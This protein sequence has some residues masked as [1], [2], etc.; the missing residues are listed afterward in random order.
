MANMNEALQFFGMTIQ[1]KR[2]QKGWTQSDLA[3][4][5]KVDEDTIAAIE[6]GE[7]DP[8]IIMIVQ[9]SK[10]LGLE[11]FADIFAEFNKEVY[12]YLDI[13]EEMDAGDKK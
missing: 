1:K 4:H 10:G 3:H 6:R 5:S 9:I 8:D 11:K 7:I 2:E 12:P 13:K